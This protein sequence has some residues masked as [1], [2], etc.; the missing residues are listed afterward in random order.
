MVHL[1]RRVPTALDVA[2]QALGPGVELAAVLRV[3]GRVAAV[4]ASSASALACEEAATRYLLGP[5]V[6]ACESL[7]GQMVTDVGVEERWT[8][9]RAA[10]ATR[11]LRSALTIPA[12]VDPWTEIALTA[13]R[14]G[15]GPWPSGAVATLDRHAQAL[16]LAVRLEL[17]T[18][19]DLGDASHPDHDARPPVPGGVEGGA[20]SSALHAELL[21][22]AVLAVMRTN[23]CGARD[24]VA[25]LVGASSGRAATIADVAV[26]VLAAVGG[27]PDHEDAGRRP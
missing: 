20:G 23:A 7:R 12:V 13:Y 19:P 21:D 9:W 4:G 14:N 5:C 6:D 27:R 22:R 25:I 2:A 1:F 17:D 15:A 26:T 24:A 3:R 18:R 8:P 11:G 10:A 16:A